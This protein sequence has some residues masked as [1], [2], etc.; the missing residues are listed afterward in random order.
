[1]ALLTSRVRSFC[2]SSDVF[3]HKQLDLHDHLHAFLLGKPAEAA[4]AKRAGRAFERST[5]G[6]LP[7]D[8]SRPYFETV[9]YGLQ[10][11]QTLALFNLGKMY[12]ASLL[13]HILSKR[14]RIDFGLLSDDD[15][16]RLKLIEWDEKKARNGGAE[17]DPTVEELLVIE[18]ASRAFLAV[19]FAGK[20]APSRAA[21][22]AIPEVII[23]LTIA[24]FR[25][26]GLRE[27]DMKKLLT[28]LLLDFNKDAGAP[29]D[30]RKESLELANWQKA[31]LEQWKRT[32]GEEEPPEDGQRPLKMLQP[33]D[34]RHLKALQTFL[35]REP[36]AILFYLDNIVFDETQRDMTRGGGYASEK[37]S[38]RCLHVPPRPMSRHTHA[39]TPLRPA[40]CAPYQ[41]R[42]HDTR[43]HTR[44]R[45]AGPDGWPGRSGCADP[46]VT[47]SCHS[48]HIS[49]AF[50]S[51]A[52]LCLSLA[53]E[54]HGPRQ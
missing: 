27:R 40:N 26:E 42:M 14:N 8:A 23:G 46:T 34:K 17:R 29:H 44:A 18:R 3:K 54:W 36:Q 19:P 10:R 6:G 52:R 7:H 47:S 51:S 1:V 30:S 12:L 37:L 48:A 13:P 49:P 33:S 24:A 50:S 35:G 5:G 53:G 25:T 38:A 4:M 16:K 31:A 2:S 21:E 32:H 41:R 15:A 43:L 20:D 28:Q 11:T 9:M 22:F 39:R 45:R